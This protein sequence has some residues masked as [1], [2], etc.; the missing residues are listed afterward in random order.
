LVHRAFSAQ[1]Q[2]NSTAFN[3][4]YSSTQLQ[5]ATYDNSDGSNVHTY[6]YASEFSQARP[7]DWS[8]DIGL[9]AF[10]GANVT[11]GVPQLLTRNDSDAPQGQVC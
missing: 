1:L 4:S 3:A 9:D 8:H 10:S 5:N 7:A 2:A 6:T 11:A